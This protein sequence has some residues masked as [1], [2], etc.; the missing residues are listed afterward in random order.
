MRFNGKSAIGYGAASASASTSRWRSH[1][2][3]GG[4]RRGSESGRGRCGCRRDRGCW[5]QALGVAMDVTDERAVDAG[6]AAVVG[7]SG[8][9][10]YW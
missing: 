4:G 9:S 1:A 7:H 5:R 10:T 3:R 8:A 2:G 6:V